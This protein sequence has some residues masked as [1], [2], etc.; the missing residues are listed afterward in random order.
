[1][2]NTADVI[3]K[4]VVFVGGGHAHVHVVKMIAM[5]R[6][7][8]TRYTLITRDVN[9]PY[10]GMLP[11]HVAGYYTFD[12]CHIDLYQLCTF[13]GVRMIHDEVCNIDI[14][15]KKLF[16]TTG[17]PAIHYD[18]LSLDIG[19]S[20]K[21]LPQLQTATELPNITPVKPIDKFSKRWKIIRNRTKNTIIKG[22]HI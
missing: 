15:N 10:S 4:E 3:L 1:M 2:M 19:V 17:R 6:V 7:K 20:P 22:N 8:G 21:P 12:E 14:K 18:I 16:C 9:T 11:G 13:A 5:N